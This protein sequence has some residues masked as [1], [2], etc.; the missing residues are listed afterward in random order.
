MPTNL[1][2]ELD[3]SRPVKGR[4]IVTPEIQTIQVRQGAQGDLMEFN[5]VAAADHGSH[6][7]K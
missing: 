7:V 1:A 3:Y 4:R 2:G 6:V 5:E